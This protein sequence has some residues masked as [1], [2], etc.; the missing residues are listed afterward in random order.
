MFNRRHNS[1]ADYGDISKPNGINLQLTLQSMVFDELYLKCA[2][3]T[4]PA[5]HIFAMFS[6]HNIICSNLHLLFFKCR[7]IEIKTRSEHWLLTV[8]MFT[9]F[10]MHNIVFSILHLLYF[11]WRKIQ[12]KLY[13]NIADYWNLK[14]VLKLDC[15][16]CQT[17]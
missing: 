9:M 16:S 8:D 15:T 2:C 1:R 14:N 17:W 11:K 3:Q 4:V 12:I 10:S 5:M 6:R 7:K 13:Q